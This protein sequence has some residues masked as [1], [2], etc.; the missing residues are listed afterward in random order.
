MR[1]R[2]KGIRFGMDF[3]KSELTNYDAFRK[4]KSFPGDLGKNE[5]YLFVSKGQN[6]LVWILNLIEIETERKDRR[7]IDSRRWRLEGGTWNPLLLQNY[8][9]EAGIEL[10]G[11]RRFEEI[12]EEQKDR[13]RKQHKRRLREAA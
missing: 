1:I 12:Y 2:L 3:R 9:N 5:A 11:I 13:K 10:I 6:Q 8:A 7:M 4:S